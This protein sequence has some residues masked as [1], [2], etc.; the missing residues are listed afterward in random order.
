MSGTKTTVDF[1]F[2]VNDKVKTKYG[3]IGF[4]E[5]LGWDSRGKTYHV[6]INCNTSCWLHPNDFK[7][8]ESEPDCEREQPK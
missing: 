3:E 6:Q 2:G 4:V 1:D 5:T 7:L 8:Y